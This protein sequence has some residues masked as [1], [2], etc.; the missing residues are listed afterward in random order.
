[1]SMFSDLMGKIFGEEDEAEKP[2][3]T[4]KTAK[5]AKSAKPAFE[6]KDTS[7]LEAVT[8]SAKKAA[9]KS[10]AKKAAKKK[11]AARSAAN[12]VDVAKLLDRKARARAKEGLD[13]RKSI[14]DLMK[15]CG[16]N[17]SFASRKE[18]AI[19]LGYPR[20]DAV[21]SKSAKMNIW[22]HK[23]MMRQIIA[24]GGKVPKKLLD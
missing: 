13:W 21:G 11:K 8:G 16:M 5:S 14:V 10:A 19:E 4:K 18:L 15:L 24:N 12:P 20:K 3:T 22:L 17:S 7:E 9:K 6:I 23:Q 2:K 1:M